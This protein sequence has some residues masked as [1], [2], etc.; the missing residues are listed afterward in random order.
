MRW[1]TTL[2]KHTK[3]KFLCAAYFSLSHWL[4]FYYL[5]S[6]LAEPPA[7][8]LPQGLVLWLNLAST[9]RHPIPLPSSFRFHRCFQSRLNCISFAGHNKP[10]IV[11]LASRW[12][13]IRVMEREGSFVVEK[14]VVVGVWRTAQVTRITLRVGSWS[15]EDKGSLNKSGL[16][17]PMRLAVGPVFFHRGE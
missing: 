16:F 3:V 8:N 15:I 10:G 7:Q 13:T 5:L 2:G 17:G 1:I 4:R 11:R 14:Q 6:G 12:D 9:G